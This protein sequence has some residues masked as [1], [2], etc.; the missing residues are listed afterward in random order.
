MAMLWLLNEEF[1]PIDYIATIPE[2]QAYKF[3]FWRMIVDRIH[4]LKAK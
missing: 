4:Y 3:I 1:E 2:D